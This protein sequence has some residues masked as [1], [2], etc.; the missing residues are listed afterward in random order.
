MIS[1]EE[2]ETNK[3]DRI[4]ELGDEISRTA[5]DESVPELTR[6]ARVASVIALAKAVR[7]QTYEQA[8]G[9]RE[10]IAKAGINKHN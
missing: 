4:K 3:T 1:K 9:H 6:L 8:T 2:F 10:A 7:S 5:D